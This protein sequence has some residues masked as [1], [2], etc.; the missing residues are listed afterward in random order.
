[1]GQGTGGLRAFS[2]STTAPVPRGFL[3]HNLGQSLCVRFNHARH[4][5]AVD[6]Q[7][8]PAGF[9][10]TS[11]AKNLQMMRYGGRRDSSHGDNFA[12]SHLIP[13]RDGFKNSEPGLVC[14]GF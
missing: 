11:L 2:P 3:M 13:G 14:Q 6:E 9:D 10:K 5:A 7:A 4:T 12:T 1:M 8:V